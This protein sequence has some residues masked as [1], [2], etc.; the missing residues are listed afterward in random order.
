MPFP[1]P[2]WWSYY[3]VQYFGTWSMKKAILICDV[4]E[5]DRELWMKDIVTGLSAGYL[6]FAGRYMQR[7]LNENP[8]YEDD[9]SL[10][11]MG[12]DSQGF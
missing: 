11:V 5:I 10:M 1:I 6:K 2:T 4:M 8:Q 12:P 9:G 7:W 3:G